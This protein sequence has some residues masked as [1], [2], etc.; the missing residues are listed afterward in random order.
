MNDP[1]TG[2]DLS[3]LSLADFEAESRRFVL[4]MGE[5]R[6]PGKLRSALRSRRPSNEFLA[7]NQQPASRA[8]CRTLCPT[9][10]Q[11]WPSHRENA[12]VSRSPTP[13]RHS[14]GALRGATH[15]RAT[16]LSHAPKRPRTSGA[17]SEL[18]RCLRALRGRRVSRW[19]ADALFRPGIALL[20]LRRVRV[21]FLH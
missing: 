21:G 20:T 13:D 19:L 3:R 9:G 16:V 5:R 14:V 7:L 10:L 4:P 6:A 1:G 12:P 11:R 8:A 2:S 15:A 18:H 17:P